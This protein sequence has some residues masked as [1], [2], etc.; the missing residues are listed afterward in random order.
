ML[1]VMLYS[2][3]IVKKNLRMVKCKHKQEKSASDF[4]RFISYVIYTS[5][6]QIYIQLFVKK[7]LIY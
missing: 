6:V 2:A 3:V 7:I 4:K 5:G 1:T